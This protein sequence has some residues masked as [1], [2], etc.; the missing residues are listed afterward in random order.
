MTQLTD[1]QIKAISHLIW[2]DPETI[3]GIRWFMNAAD[4][5]AVRLSFTALLIDRILVHIKEA[6]GLTLQQKLT[7]PQDSDTRSSD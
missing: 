2:H 3:E 1:D 7:L 6:T 5:E 4:A